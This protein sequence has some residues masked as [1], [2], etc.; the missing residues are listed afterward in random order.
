MSEKIK[1]AEK[2]GKELRN[3]PLTDQRKTKNAVIT[4]PMQS[5][6]TTSATAVIHRATGGK[7]E[8]RPMA[9][10]TGLRI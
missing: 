7:F 8:W 2:L 9:S 4:I 5:K 10:T 1:N 3:L 6:T